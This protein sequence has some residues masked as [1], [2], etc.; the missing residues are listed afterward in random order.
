MTKDSS[1]LV[2]GSAKLPLKSILL[3]IATHDLF[4]S[5][6]LFK[7]CFA[8]AGC[9]NRTCQEYC[10]I[11]LQKRMALVVNIPPDVAQTV[12]TCFWTEDTNFLD[13]L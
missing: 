6:H 10:V 9:A 13:R 3:T 5:I 7:I 8:F 11:W 12:K 1:T 2:F 4:F